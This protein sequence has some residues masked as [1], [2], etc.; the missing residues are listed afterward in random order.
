MPS[1]FSAFTPPLHGHDAAPSHDPELTRLIRAERIRMLFAPTVP[2]SVVSAL[3]AIGLAIAVADQTGHRWAIAWASLC[4][5]AS[6]V[7]L[8]QWQAYR[9]A[10]QHATARGTERDDPRW[11]HKLT[12]TCALHG[13]CWGLAGVMM[14]VRDMVT[15]AVMGA[16]L[17]GACAVCTF[18]L[19]AHFRPNLAINLPMLVPA[20]L[21]LLF[22]QDAY[23]FFGGAGLLS[24]LALLL[25]ESRRAERRITELLWLRFTTDRIARERTAALVMAQRHSAIKDQFLATMSHE[26]RTPLH[27]ILGLARLTLERLPARPGVLAESRHQVEL[28]ERAGEHLLHI[29]N[30][31]LDFSR[32]EAGKLHI[33]HAP[34]ELRALLDEVLG[35][36]RVNASDKGLRLL[37][38]VRLPQPCWVQGDAARIRQMLHNLLGNA[39]KFTD[40]GEVRLVVARD[41]AQGHGESTLR[42]TI[43]DSGVG[44]PPEQLPLI[45]DAFH[46]ADGSFVR[47]HKGTGLG[48]TITREIARAMDGDVV[49]VSE[50]GR[51]SAFTIT[52]PLPD[53]PAPGP[54]VGE[55]RSEPAAGGLVHFN[56]HVL[57]VEDNPVNALV[58]DAMLRRHG[59]SVTRADNGREALALLTHDSR[60]FQLVL[61]DLQM[62]EMGGMEASRLLRRWES[63]NGMLPMP[64][65]ALTANA[66]SSDRAQCLAAGMDDHLAKPFRADELLAVLHRHLAGHSIATGHTG[67]TGDRPAGHTH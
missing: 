25:F 13:A 65:V 24:L 5:L 29:I 44:I 58:A 53:I 42:F 26:M 54:A 57:L 39:I 20:G 62:P 16:T 32:I 1:G 56:A 66:L 33:E 49:C 67:Q 21:A 48:L 43:Q 12:L 63:E 34:F 38:D 23:G 6:V 31:V 50:L 35:L 14:P 17:V 47:R 19:Q 8:L 51:G 3:A 27:G 37:T 2:V 9:R 40:M 4:V 7:R 30:D 41:K 11:L 22:R 61:M 45:F 10:G 52:V 46:Q 60:A 55:L 28:I 18:T 64:V 36:L 15:S 59:L